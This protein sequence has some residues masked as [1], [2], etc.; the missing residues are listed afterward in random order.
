MGDFITEKPRKVK[1]SKIKK[2]KSGSTDSPK[3][4][5]SKNA[6]K[7]SLKHSKATLHK[8]KFVDDT[9]VEVL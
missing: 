7:S 9:F 4:R 3:R 8:K 6:S 1:K 5:K 2:E